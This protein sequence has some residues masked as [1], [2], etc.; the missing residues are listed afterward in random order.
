MSELIRNGYRIVVGENGSGTPPLVLVHGW[1]C[2]RSFFAPQ[3]AF[4]GVHH[5]VVAI[6][7]PGHGDSDK[8][9]RDYSI[10]SLAADVAWVCDQLGLVR[11]VI[12]G[13][14]M[15]GSIA[16]ELAGSRPDR[17]AAAILLDTTIAP[18][19]AMVRAWRDLAA[20]LRQPRPGEALREVMEQRYF[21]ATDDAARK[22][23]L[24]ERMLRAPQ[25]VMASG[26]EG[27]ATWDSERAA[28]AVRGPVLFIAS[29]GPRADVARF[30]TL[31]PQL[32]HGQVVG[33][34]HFVQ[35]EVPEQ[36]NAMIE[37]FLR[38]LPQRRVPASG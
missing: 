18:S 10:P 3:A 34:G 28:A 21:A 12:I 24:I 2:D 11:P 26:M 20:R 38:L 13:H 33:A 1:C 32:V 19:A 17:I 15:G 5:R 30:K 6:D 37:R 25:H 14:S 31:C 27:I 8:P 23:A 16:L 7:M 35:L 4:F 36:V 22:A 9:I 29:S